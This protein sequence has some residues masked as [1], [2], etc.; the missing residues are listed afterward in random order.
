MLNAIT[1]NY[2]TVFIARVFLYSDDDG[3]RFWAE[4]LKVK[5]EKK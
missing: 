4:F 2:L 1:I 3:A 5:K